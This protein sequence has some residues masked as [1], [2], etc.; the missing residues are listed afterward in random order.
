MKSY[1]FF[2]FEQ[3]KKMFSTPSK[4]LIFRGQIALFACRSASAAARELAFRVS[5]ALETINA[6][7][8][9][10]RISSVRC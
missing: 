9:L 6:D 8:T 10:R 1:L 3:T 2:F 5:I 4:H 7:E